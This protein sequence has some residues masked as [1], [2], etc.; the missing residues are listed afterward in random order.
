[1]RLLPVLAAFALLAAGVHARADTVTLANIAPAVVDEVRKSGLVNAAIPV[2]GFVWTIEHRRPFRQPRT[3]IED[4]AGSA[5]GASS[6]HSRATLPDGK[7][8][9]SDY[10]SVR[11]LL[12]V[13]PADEKLGISASGLTVPPASGQKFRLSG[14]RDGIVLDQVCT[15][16]A[17]MPASQVHE[18]L[19]G[20]AV[21]IACEG[22]GKYRGMTAQ[23]TSDVVWLAKL[24]V[25]LDRR[26]VFES[27]LGR[28]EFSNAVT[29]FKFNDSTQEGRAP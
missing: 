17:R 1:M 20:E 10:V 23:V 4:I 25:F 24:G 2:R 18:S 15:T 12:K 14:E 13:G 8:E 3:I 9:Y 5:D 11:G 6:A 22:E 27:P 16:R 21:A 19:P 28:F 29:D 26:D 7:V